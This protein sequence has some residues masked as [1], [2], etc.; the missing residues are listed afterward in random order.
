MLYFTLALNKSWSAEQHLNSFYANVLKVLIFVTDK[1]ACYFAIY[2]KKS[3]NGKHTEKK[4]DLREIFKEVVVKCLEE[5]KDVMEKEVTE[6]R[7]DMLNSYHE[8]LRKK[9][10]K[11]IKDE[12]FEL[13]TDVT[14]IEAVIIESTL[15]EISSKAKL[16]PIN[17]FLS[18]NVKNE[19]S[20]QEFRTLR[21]DSVK[22][23]K[24]EIQKFKGDLSC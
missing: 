20:S 24:L 4:F 17:K 10:I 6:K 7:L 22:L 12:I 15:F 13:E 14:V 9:T 21:S 8:T 3:Y 16:N 18:K 11:T 2:K 23:P 19:N 1:I 5:A